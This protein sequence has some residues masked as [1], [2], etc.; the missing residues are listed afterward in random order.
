MD[1]YRTYVLE[2]EEMNRQIEED[3][4]H[5]IV[6]MKRRYEL[7]IEELKNTIEVSQWTLNF[8]LSRRAGFTNTNVM[9]AMWVKKADWTSDE[10]EVTN[11]QSTFINISREWKNKITLPLWWKKTD[12]FKILITRRLDSTEC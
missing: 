11:N 9:S 10:C 12:P 6:T 3:A 8:Y 2:S 5:E 1:E 7:D 4:D